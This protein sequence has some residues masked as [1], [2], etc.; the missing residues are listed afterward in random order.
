[1]NI[2]PPSA[3]RWL[4]LYSTYKH[5][6]A[7]RGRA[8]QVCSQMRHCA[9]DESLWKSLSAQDFAQERGIGWLE[10]LKAPDQPWSRLY[11]QLAVELLQ[12]RARWRCADVDAHTHRDASS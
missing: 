5:D 11:R 1:M 6:P 10:K 2:L 9:S 3:T 8:N 12:C 4:L 7:T